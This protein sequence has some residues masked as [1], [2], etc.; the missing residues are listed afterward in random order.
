[1][2]TTEKKTRDI[3]QVVADRV[4]LLMQAGE[5][6][7]PPNY[8]P[9][10]AIKSAYLILEETVDKNKVSVLESCTR[11]SIANALMEMVILGLSPV[12]KQCAFIARGNK[13]TC[14]VQYQGTITLAKRYAG[15][16]DVSAQV[17]YEND[18]LEV[19]IK[20][21]KK[22]ITKHVQDI[23]NIDINKITGAY[24]VL[25][26]DNGN[27]H[28]EY[29]T[30]AQIRQAWQ[31][32]SSNGDSQAHRKFP[33]QMAIKTVINRACKL[34]IQGSDDS[35]LYDDDESTPYKRGKDVSQDAQ[36]ISMDDEPESEPV[37]QLPGT[38]EPVKDDLF[39]EPKKAEPEVIKKDSP[40]F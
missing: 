23:K 9:E 17:V 14:E 35:A 20:Q 39:E 37:K 4:Q 6:T 22:S 31:Q 24:A 21:G 27:A 18:D 15:L 11:V 19:E 13:L 1:M 2:S 5:L 33:D 38:K 16:K 10:N 30:I 25:A 32:G 26:F 12:K 29:M 3:T 7:A 36:I 34:F 28:T 40:G 8:S